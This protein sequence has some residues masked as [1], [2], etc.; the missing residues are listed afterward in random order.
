MCIWLGVDVVIFIHLTCLI[1]KQVL[2]VTYDRIS[3]HKQCSALSDL[4]RFCF[5]VYF[6]RGK[7]L[8]FYF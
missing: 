8:H 3:L 4:I 5:R 6:L 7:R 1:S 2:F